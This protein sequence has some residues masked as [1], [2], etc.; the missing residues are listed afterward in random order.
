MQLLTLT[1]EN[2]SGRIT[3]ESLL[4]GRVTNENNTV[5]SR[6]GGG[7]DV[8]SEGARAS[9]AKSSPPARCNPA[10]CCRSRPTPICAML[11]APR[12][13]AR[14]CWRIAL[15]GQRWEWQ[16]EQG[17]TYEL[18]KLVAVVT[19]RD[20]ALPSVAAPIVLERLRAAGAAAL[21]DAHAQ[22]WAARWATADAEIAG[23]AQIQR[24]VRFALYHLIGAAHPDERASIGARALTGERY[25]GH[26]FWD[27]ETFVWPFYLSTHP[28]PRARC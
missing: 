20:T 21:L 17:Q 3:L 4:D 23:D 12:S 10:M 5:A 24:Q 19:S 25:R 22:A 27:T 18:H 14:P 28:P 8:P 16:A 2:Y 26:I 6:A 11:P 9:P 7:A 1:P 15:V 13:P